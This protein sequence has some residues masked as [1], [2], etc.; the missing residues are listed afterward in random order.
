M[1]FPSGNCGDKTSQISVVKVF[2]SLH[3]LSINFEI[4]C[5]KSF[6]YLEKCPVM[7]INYFGSNL[8][9]FFHISQKMPSNNNQKEMSQSFSTLSLKLMKSQKLQQKIFTNVLLKFCNFHKIIFTLENK[10]VCLEVWF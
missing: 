9:T 2:L 4:I 8:F 1:I 7:T 10:N 5:L 3:S 6:E